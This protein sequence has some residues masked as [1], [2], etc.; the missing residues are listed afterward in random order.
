D[1]TSTSATQAPATTAST[2]TTGIAGRLLT[3]NELRGF[4]RTPPSVANTV[5][6]WLAAT[7]TPSQQV[8]SETRRL[9]RLGFVAGAHGDL[10]G[11]GKDGASVVEQFKTPGGARSELANVVKMFKANAAARSEA[12]IIAA[13][14]RLYRRV[15]G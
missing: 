12:A 15:H 1:K 2:A 8:A 3:G 4:T 7:Q 10:T 9:T 11:A 13:A 6:A 14:K 5:S